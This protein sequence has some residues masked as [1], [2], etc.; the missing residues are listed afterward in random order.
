MHSE[1]MTPGTILSKYTRMYAEG[2]MKSI[3]DDLA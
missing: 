3:E 1:N 2:T